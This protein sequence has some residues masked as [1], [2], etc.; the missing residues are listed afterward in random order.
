MPPGRCS[1]V[2]GT[3]LCGMKTIAFSVRGGRVNE[4]RVNEFS[5]ANLF[6]YAVFREA[7]EPAGGGSDCGDGHARVYRRTG[8][9]LISGV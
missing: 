8:G 2:R 4:S 5:D 3:D 1:P 6:R 7:K 9:V